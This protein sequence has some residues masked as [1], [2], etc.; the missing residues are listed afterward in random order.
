[1]AVLILFN[2]ATLLHAQPYRCSATLLKTGWQIMSFLRASLLLGEDP[3]TTVRALGRADSA[4][5][6]RYEHMIVTGINGYAVGIAI[7]CHIH[8]PLVGSSIDDA[9]HRPRG[10]ISGRQ[11]VSVVARVVPGLVHTAHVVDSRD[12]SAG[13]AVNYVLVGW[14]GFSVVVRATHKEIVTRPLHDAT[15]HTVGHDEAV[16][17]DR[18]V[19]GADAGVDFVHG[20]DRKVGGCIG[21]R[22]QKVAGVG[23]KGR[24]SNASRGNGSKGGSTK[25]KSRSVMARDIRAPSTNARAGD[26]T[27][28]G[29][30]AKEGERGIRTGKTV[31]TVDRDGIVDWQRTVIIDLAKDAGGKV[32]GTISLKFIHWKAVRRA[33]DDAAHV[34]ESNKGQS[35]V[36]ICHQKNFVLFVP[37]H[38]VGAQVSA[39]G[40]G[41]GTPIRR[42]DAPCDAS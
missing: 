10:H 7:R 17:D 3:D 28:N 36:T 20:S 27:R 1:M 34:D 31:S 40:I 18:T 21:I 5:L 29:R 22:H 6:Q 30:A 38:L 25:T 13:G 15:W 4:C 24:A 2:P 41:K 26:A 11:I 19:R 9:H 35:R 12:D 33:C 14:E 8:Q 32:R 39:G 16:D 23:I 42:G 37:G